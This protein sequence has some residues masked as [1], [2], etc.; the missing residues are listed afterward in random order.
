MCQ[1]HTSQQPSA[2]ATSRGVHLQDEGLPDGGQ[3]R[4]GG[5]RQLFAIWPQRGRPLPQAHPHARL[6]PR[7][8]R[9]QVVA[10]LQ[11]AAGTTLKG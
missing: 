5:R 7:R 3:P 4:G 9:L 6:H 1:Q 2:R 11:H 10:T 8:R